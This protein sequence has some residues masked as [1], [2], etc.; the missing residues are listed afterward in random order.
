MNNLRNTIRVL[1][2]KGYLE[3]IIYLIKTF[4]IRFFSKVK[5]IFLN[6]RGYNIDNSVILKGNNFFFQSTKYAVRI[7]KKS[8]I[9]QHTRISAGGAGKVSIGESV[10]ID[11]FTYIMAHDNIEIGNHT[12][13]ASFCFIVDFNHKFKS[14]TKNLVEQGYD[15][16]K[17]KIGS[18]VWIGAHVIVLPGVTIGDRAV[19]GAGSV[20][21][22]DVPGGAVAVGNPAKVIKKNNG[23]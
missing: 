16:K 22:R 21:T 9:G 17:I 14:K 23:E 3:S 4:L 19:I 18:N 13:I 12:K 8:T 2:N 7:S 11:N 5:V 6:L 1:R 10:L 20:V 15:L